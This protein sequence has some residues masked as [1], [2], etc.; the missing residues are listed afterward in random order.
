MSR[1]WSRAFVSLTIL[2]QSILALNNLSELTV[3]ESDRL[4]E[5]YLLYTNSPMCTQTMSELDYRI[6]LPLSPELA[7]EF[8]GD[9]ATACS[10]VCLQRGTHIDH[11]LH[12]LPMHVGKNLANVYSFAFDNCQKTEVG[13]LSYNPNVANLMWVNQRN[14]KVKVGTLKYGEKNTV[15]QVSYLGHKFIVEDSVT[16]AVLLEVVVEYDAVYPIGNHTS[17][18]QVSKQEKKKT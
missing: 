1:F 2:V 5:N 6:S 15:W 4:T 12:P 7:T 13:F 11:V 10:A 18:L 16:K 9:A 8:F 3:D 14:Q 17:A